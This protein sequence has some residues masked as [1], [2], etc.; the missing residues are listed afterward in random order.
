MIINTTVIIF[1]TKKTDETE[2]MSLLATKTLAVKCFMFLMIVL[3]AHSPDNSFLGFA[4]PKKHRRKTTEPKNRTNAL[5]YG[6]LPHFWE[7]RVHC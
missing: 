5:I 3:A 4:V 1:S 6:K 2:I 7:V